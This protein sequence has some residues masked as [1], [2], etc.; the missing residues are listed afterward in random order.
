MFERWTK[1][2]AGFLERGDS[3][4][5]ASAKIAELIESDDE[6]IAWFEHAGLHAWMAGQLMVQGIEVDDRELANVQ[7]AIDP[8]SFVN[9]PFDA[10]IEFFQAKVL[11]SPAE[12]AAMTDRFRRGAF[13]ARNLA[14]DAVAN[15]AQDAIS[16]V[17]AGGTSPREA[18]RAIRTGELALGIQPS[19]SAYINT[20]VR[21]NVSTAYNAGRFDAMTSP[22]VSALR[23]FWLYVTAND[24][25]VRDAHKELEGR[26][27]EAGSAEGKAYFPPLGY[28]CRC[29]MVTQSAR[30]QL[31]SFDQPR[32]R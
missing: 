13:V 14:S 24:E 17:V 5:E 22:A 15:M 11:V 23:P 20:V 28:N 29:T 9:L 18:A 19:S 3:P 10:A 31:A 32:S 8:G 6:F 12:F 7:L 21:T 25:R 26:V 4:E 30:Q 16:R 2:M 1:R 27:F